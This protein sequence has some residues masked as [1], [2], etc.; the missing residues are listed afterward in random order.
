VN[1]GPISD[2]NPDDLVV[3]YEFYAYMFVPWTKV[4]II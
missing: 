2:E 1:Q 4:S 3:A